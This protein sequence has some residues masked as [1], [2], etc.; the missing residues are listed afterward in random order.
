MFTRKMTSDSSPSTP[1]LRMEYGSQF[2]EK[3]T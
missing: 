2:S 3:I 1:K